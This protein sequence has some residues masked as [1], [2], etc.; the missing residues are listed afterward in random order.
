[1]EKLKQNKIFALFIPFIA[2]LG[3]LFFF[4]KA[5]ATRVTS[6]SVACPSNIRVNSRTGA[7]CVEKTCIDLPG[8]GEETQIECKFTWNSKNKA[9]DGGFGFGW[10]FNYDMKFTETGQ[11]GIPSQTGTVEIRRKD[12]RLDTFTWN[13]TSFISPSGLNETLEVSG[14]GYILTK[15]NGVKYSLGTDYY[16]GGESHDKLTQIV[17]VNGNVLKVDYN[18]TTNLPNTIDDPA[19]RQVS[20]GY[21]GGH[22][23]S[24]T[25]NGRTYNF[26]YDVNDNLEKVI[27]PMLGETSYQ[28]DLTTHLMVKVT[29]PKG[30]ITTI[31]YAGADS[32]VNS[33]N[34][35][36]KHIYFQYSTMNNQAIIDH[37]DGGDSIKRV[38]HN[39]DGQG[40]VISIGAASMEWDSSNN[41]TKKVD[42]NGRATLY[43]YDTNGNNTKETVAGAVVGTYEY[44]LT[45][46]KRTKSTDANNNIT[47]YYY[48][49]NGNLTRT[50][51]PM[52]KTS[53]YQYDANGLLT[54]RIE[55][56]EDTAAFPLPA[57]DIR[58]QAT[59]YE[60][61]GNGYLTKTTD[62]LGNF[63]T[64][65]YDVFGNKTSNSDKNSKTKVYEYDGLNRMTKTTDPLT[66]FETYEYDGNGNRTTY[67]NKKGIITI[68]L[69]NDLNQQTN[70]ILDP[71]GLNFSS[72]KTYDIFDHV[73]SE[74][75]EENNTTTYTYNYAGCCTSKDTLVSITDALGNITSFG[76]DNI[77]NRT[78]E[79][80]PRNY[81]TTYAY[82]SLYRITRITDALGNF[83]KY[84]YDN[85]GNRIWIKSKNG[86]GTYYLYD[87]L[88]RNTQILKRVTNHDD[89]PLASPIPDANDVYTDYE[90]DLASR[91][92][93]T[94]NPNLIPINYEYDSLGQ[95]TRVVD[96]L[97]NQTMY[98]YDAEGNKTK[99]TDARG[100]F[101]HFE[102][103]AMNRNTKIIRQV[104]ASKI[105]GDDPT[106]TYEYDSMGTQTKFTDARGKFTHFEYDN[107]NRNTKEIRQVGVSKIDGDDPTTTYEYNN[108]G[109]RTK[110]T[111]PNLN[112]T[113]YYFDNVYRLTQVVNAIS[114][115][116]TLFAYDSAGNKT[117]VTDPGGN[118]LNYYYDASNRLTSVSDT[119]G[120]VVSYE[121]DAIGNRTKTTDANN[122][123]TQ[124]AYNELERLVTVTDALTNSIQYEYDKIGNKTKVTDRNTNPTFFYYDSLN[125]LTKTSKW[126]T[127]TPSTD[128]IDTNY[129]YD[130]VGN[131]T[132][133]I[134]DLLNETAYAYD[135]L[136]QLTLVTYADTT[137]KSYEYDKNGNKI[138]RIDQAAVTT[139]YAYDDL[140][141]FNRR[142]YSTGEPEDTFEYDLGGRMT[143]NSKAYIPTAWD[144]T[145]EYDVVN[146]ATKSIQGGRTVSYAYST[147]NR[148]QTITYPDGTTAVKETSDPRW[149]LDLVEDN[150]TLDDIVDYAYDVGDRLTHAVYL[151]GIT[152]TYTHNANNWVTDLSHYKGVTRVS[153]FGYNFDNEGNRQYAERLHDTDNSEKYEY[154]NVYRLNN[155]KRGVL[156]GSKQIPTPDTQTAYTL[157]NLGNWLT[158]TKDA[159]P[160]NRTPNNM[161]EYT[162]IDGVAQ[163]HD[164]KGN[165]TEDGT[166]GNQKY[167]YDTENRL[168]EVL[169]T[170]D[171]EIAS[172]KYDAESRRIEKA[173]NGGN[174]TGFYYNG[175]RVIEERVSASTTATYVYGAE[176]IDDVVTMTRGGSTYYYAKNS[177][178]SVDVVTNNAGDI[179]EAYRYD[180][181]GQ[182][183]V[184][185]GEGTD[186]TWFTN[187]DV[188]S[189]TNTSAIGNPYMFTS[190]R[191]EDKTETDL[192]YYRAR[193]YSGERGR[194]LQHDPLRYV[195]GMNMY[196]YVRSNPICFKD[197]LGTWRKKTTVANTGSDTYIAE[198]KDETLPHALENLAVQVSGE[199]KD[200]VCIWPEYMSDSKNYPKKVKCG[201]EFDVSNLSGNGRTSYL[202]IFFPDNSTQDLKW[203]ALGWETPSVLNPDSIYDM[204]VKSSGE[205]KTPISM[206][207]IVGHSW[208][209]L[210]TIG[211]QPDEGDHFA[212]TFYTKSITAIPSRKAGQGARGKND[213]NTFSRASA[214][215]GPNRCWFSKNAKVYGI[216]CKTLK[217]A[218][219]FANKSL[220]KNASAYGTIVSISV[221][222]NAI[223]YDLG[224]A[225][226]SDEKIK[227]TAPM[228]VKKG[229]KLWRKYRG[230]L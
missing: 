20:M 150:T 175:A 81:T 193:Y 93:R 19:G 32:G 45:Y 216:G 146:R 178:G 90:Y 135:D 172:Y 225:S 199:K 198:L 46:N 148:T 14:T 151:N 230:G 51:A 105:D 163:V 123:S 53:E 209:N 210:S 18:N 87:N 121:Y 104:G 50:E 44:D 191:Y 204:I 145:Y 55:E 188:I 119:L 69:Y 12:T 131:T 194:F 213:T 57:P 115:P 212:Q 102:Y 229:I 67:T 94:T 71:T 171:V 155:F 38:T 101:T 126:L 26:Q 34:S 16:D 61:D 43:E 6:V 203:I 35:S 228:H 132:K 70:K 112:A 116:P 184:I 30:N 29:E 58:T 195:D 103:D 77:G 65:G 110:V 109:N 24:M 206:F 200:W 11:P 170:A 226:L 215:K 108:V 60:Y 98:E 141:R 176:G 7:C 207:Q 47:N 80:N 120:D 41:I 56:I 40:R 117:Q 54:K 137:I 3:V 161:N 189:A 223:S 28:Y 92:T 2:F 202:S 75:D 159:T 139:N 106:T 166:Y 128:Y 192:Y 99:V 158:K 165:L 149:R 52:S 13:G 113:T 25:Y 152:S 179:V 76:Y 17:D 100:K 162:D 147:A 177:L 72:S 164:V 224:S 205:G 10:H 197:P 153:E 73:V 39:Y 63:T 143:R 88:Y 36:N 144:V 91:N 127:D 84:A 160:E 83:E 37:Y 82:D 142:Y 15:K 173:I 134:D 185:T 136:N 201:D 86:R 49:A 114:D 190:R 180:A 85:E 217:W 187:D 221:Y 157:D 31:G 124:S 211:S 227:G 74:T 133:A 122:N 78:S 27:D 218:E 125:R 169:T 5:H 9:A 222:S 66:Y 220:R 130:E 174:T 4:A 140:N 68:Y 48:D 186:T 219:D 107:A 62:D 64:S 154:D 96:I 214:K 79:T 1:M 89:P 118:V 196:E 208:S 8:F 183:A 33:V 21:T 22:M 167:Q 138:K 129:Q 23:S 59:S 181:Y 168:T 97:A 182:P 95:L 42:E 111:D 156:D